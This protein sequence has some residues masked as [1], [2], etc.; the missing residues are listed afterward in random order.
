MA[1]CFEATACAMRL[2]PVLHLPAMQLLL[3]GAAVRAAICMAVSWRMT[4]LH[5]GCRDSGSLIMQQA[6]S[7]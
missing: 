3:L 2:A 1:S 5:L 4:D 6:A 7:Q